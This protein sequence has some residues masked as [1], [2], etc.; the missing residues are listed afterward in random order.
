MEENFNP[1]QRIKRRFFAMRNGVV[2]DALRRAG[3]PCRV[4]FG[5]NLPQI[6]EIAGEVAPG[7]RPELAEA[8]WANKTTRESMLLAPMLMDRATTDRPRAE[9][10][11]REAPYPE[12]TDVVCHRLLRHLPFAAELAESLSADP[13]ERVRY[14]ALRLM[15]NVVAQ[16]PQRA[17]A[18]AHAELERD[19]AYTRALASML[20][21]EAEWLAGEAAQD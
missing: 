15:M 13:D 9:A 14:G 16:H 17:L 18:M 4:I 12:V 20:A 1:M 5:L 7:E 2:A 10:M 8:L 21:D 19:C 6:V 3:C 11:L